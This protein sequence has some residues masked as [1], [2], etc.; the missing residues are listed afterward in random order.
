MRRHARFYCAVASS[1]HRFAAAAAPTDTLP[2]SP[3]LARSPQCPR[4]ASSSA[5]W[6]SSLASVQRRRSL[7]R[8]VR[9]LCL[10]RPPFHSL[11]I[12]LA[13]SLSLSL[14]VVGALKDLYASTNGP[15]WINNSGWNNAS[16]S[17]C[18]WYGVTCANNQ[19]VQLYVH[20][21]PD[22]PSPHEPMNGQPRSLSTPA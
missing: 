8:S 2:L 4:S 9:S 19:V 10:H 21:R 12:P 15:S 20:H 11:N 3:C 7:P 6:S 5:F 14:D 22:T 1:L 16:S 18:S 17:P 13:P